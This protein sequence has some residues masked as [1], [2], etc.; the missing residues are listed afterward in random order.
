MSAESSKEKKSELE[1]FRAEIAEI[2]KRE[3]LKKEAWEKREK[4]YSR[5]N[6]LRS[7]FRC[8]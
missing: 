7:P 8:N 2:K 1:L 4:E 3:M 6:S 5:E